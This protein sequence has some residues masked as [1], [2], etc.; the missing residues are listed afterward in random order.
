MADRSRVASY[1]PGALKERLR[2]V[3]AMSGM[4][5]SEYIREAVEEKLERDAESEARELVAEYRVR[6]EAH[7]KRIAVTR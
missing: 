3:C 4:P 2:A 7:R 6:L 1:L 5:E